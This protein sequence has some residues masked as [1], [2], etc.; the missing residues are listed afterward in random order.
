MSSSFTERIAQLGPAQRDLLE[1]RLD[2]PPVADKPLT[3]G[4]QKQEHPASPTQK[5]MWFVHH[6]DPASPVFNNGNA[7]RIRGSLDVDALSAALS[8]L[9]QRHEVLRTTY[10]LVDGELMQ[11][12]QESPDSV[13]EV[14]ETEAQG[15]NLSERLRQEIEAEASR[16]FDLESDLMYRAVLYRLAEDDHVLVRS[17]HHIA[18]DRWSVALANREIS[19]LYR[20]HTSGR[21][22]VLADLPVQYADFA[23]WQLDNLAADKAEARLRF[24]TSHIAGVPDYLDIPTDHPRAHAQ[25]SAGS[26]RSRLSD[27]QA[28]RVRQVARE[29]GA[30]PFMVLLAVYGA[31]MG[32]YTRSDQLLVGVPVALRTEPE[33]TDMI[34]PFINTVVLRLDLRGRPTFAEL[35]ERV[36]RASLNMIAHQDLPFDELVREVAPDRVATRTPLFQIMFDYLNTPHSELELE[37]LE[38]EA[39]PLEPA[40]TAHDITLYIEDQPSGIGSR[41]EYRAD[42][43]DR[44]TIGAIAGAYDSLVNRLITDPAILIDDQGMLDAR[45]EDRVR[46]IGTGPFADTAGNVLEALETKRAQAPDATAVESGHTSFSYD[47]LASMARQVAIGLREHGV[48]SGQRVALLLNRSVELLAGLIGVMMSG[49]IAV[50]L[51][52]DQ[53]EAR[54]SE[55]LGAAE[56]ALMVTDTPEAP[57]SDADISVFVTDLFDREMADD[58]LGFTP[59][60]SL[61]ATDPAYVVF[62]S[63]ST[64]KPKGVLVGHGSLANFAMAACIA[65]GLEP[66]DRVLQFASPGFDTIV[67]EVFPALSIGATVVMRPEELFGSFEAFERFSEDQRI[68][69]LDLPTAWWHNWVEDLDGSGRPLPT[70]LRMVIVGGEAA[71]SDLWRVWTGLAGD[72]HWVNSYG[73]SEGTVVVSTFEPTAAYQPMGQIMPIGRPIQNTTLLV[74]DSYGHPVPPRVPGELVIEG[75]LLA[76]CNLGDEETRGFS[77]GIHSAHRR[78]RTGDRARVMPDGTLEFVGR[79]D[80]QVKVRGTRVEPAEVERALLDHPAVADAAVVPD[81][82]SDLVGHIVVTDATADIALVREYLAT[83]LPEPMIPTRWLV[84]DALPKTPG[85]KVDRRSLGRQESQPVAPRNGR[86]APRSDLESRLAGIWESVLGTSDISVTD[87][88]FDLG[89]H[90]L[91]GVRMLSHVSSTFEVDLPLRVI[92]ETPTIESMARF[93]ETAHA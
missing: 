20:A 8:E 27:E 16:P 56:P 83:R 49:G 30:T 42:L 7:V 41:W 70:P 73:P 81:E 88:F 58:S 21:E 15:E 50:L 25:G 61:Q 13:L 35:V 29:L 85:G 22:P 55:M 33:L 10:R 24:F 43:F 12:V 66:E 44:A 78:Y 46:S 86:V 71:R 45:D 2:T 4:E 3:K 79:I 14:R 60:V 64:G 23:R 92:F 52:R 9:I 26:L 77:E 68:T 53:P 57:F 51:D 36:R 37:G 38:L 32:R 91:L 18:F 54:L 6:L 17:G 34:G 40:N 48:G 67:E 74:T 1:R 87:S 69:V 89:G 82:G 93:L 80:S 72:R 90:S 59:L 31:L 28:S 19:E 39:T 65:Y 47:Q 75:A 84:H 62:T 76:M 11:V 63:G 5:S